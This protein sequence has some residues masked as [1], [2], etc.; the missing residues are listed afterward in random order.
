MKLRIIFFAIAALAA[1]AQVF[2]SAGELLPASA[3][4]SNL[5]VRAAN[6]AAAS[7]GMKAVRQL[8]A[9]ICGLLLVTSPPPRYVAW[10]TDAGAWSN[11]SAHSGA[12]IEG[13]GL[14]GNGSI[15]VLA[16]TNGAHEALAHELVHLALK[17]TSTGPLPLWFEEGCANHFGWLAAQA[18]ARTQG[19]NLV[20]TL[21]AMSPSELL[22]HDVLLGCLNY[23]ATVTADRAFYREAEELVRY[24]HENIGPGGFR[25]LA[26]ALAKNND[27]RDCLRSRFGYRDDD[28]KTL[29]RAIDV[30]STTRQER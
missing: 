23:P 6:A 29:D 18:V 16:Q 4:E 24:L 1:R 15:A 8:H 12:D 11:F 28:L 9:E 19:R 17:Q 14:A 13:R 5:V 22:T 3:A 21:P 20:R 7:E 2:E 26:V 25:D 30:R 10:F 27:L